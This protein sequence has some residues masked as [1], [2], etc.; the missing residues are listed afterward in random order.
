[1][2]VYKEKNRR[3]TTSDMSTKISPL[4]VIPLRLPVFEVL[5]DDISDNDMIVS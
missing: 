1:M 3:I 2:I 5:A 4:S